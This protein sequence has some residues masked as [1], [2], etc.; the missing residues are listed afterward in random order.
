MIDLSKETKESLAEH[1][2]TV[3]NEREVLIDLL[4]ECKQHLE[5]REDYLIEDFELG[6]TN[7]YARLFQI[8]NNYRGD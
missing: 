4:M 6:Y 1:I 7:L 3:E 2:E 8:E 5:Y